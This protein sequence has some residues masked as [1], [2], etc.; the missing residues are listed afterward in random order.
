MGNKTTGPTGEAGP[1]GPTGRPGEAAQTEEVQFFFGAPAQYSRVDGV[2][3]YTQFTWTS[4]CEGGASII[5]VQASAD[6]THWVQ[7]D[8]KECGGGGVVGSGLPIA[9]PYYRI[10]LDSPGSVTAVYTGAY[11]S[12]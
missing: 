1:T 8:V 7:Q 5:R 12:N 3:G 10:E 4:V 2:S 11:L 6:G 9:A